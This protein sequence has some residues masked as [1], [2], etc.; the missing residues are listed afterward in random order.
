MSSN[1][2]KDSHGSNVQS[3]GG[4]YG[5]G[6]RDLARDSGH[7]SVSFTGLRNGMFTDF[8]HTAS[9]NKDMFRAKL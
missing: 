5:P 8:V 9:L 7:A 4:K 2:V 3:G 6:G 1:T